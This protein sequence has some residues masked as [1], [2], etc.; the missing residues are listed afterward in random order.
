[1]ES[2]KHVSRTSPTGVGVLVL[3]AALGGAIIGF[4]TFAAS[5]VHYL[6]V[7]FPIGMGFAVGGMISAA[8]RLSRVPNPLMAGSSG[9][10]IGLMS[11]GAMHYSCYIELR[12]GARDFVAAKMAEE[13][14]LDAQ[15]IASFDMRIVDEYFDVTM[16]T[17]TGSTGFW[18]FMKRTASVGMQPRSMYLAP[19]GSS[20][21]R[22]L[23]KS[24]A[25]ALRFFELTIIIGIAFFFAIASA[26][27]PFCA[28]CRLWYS[29]ERHIG[30][31]QED[32][33]ERFLGLMIAGEFAKAG[34]L[35]EDE[36]LPAPSV[37][38]SVQECP[39]TATCERIVAVRVSSCD[40]ENRVETKQV[41]EGMISEDQHANLVAAIR[42][43]SES[44]DENAEDESATAESC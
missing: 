19:S 2:Y 10:L 36:Y 12:W 1:M 4:A 5:L 7:L 34:E 38:V 35:V 9:I 17:D 20:D 32:C 33:A 29:G 15:A 41:L 26:R 40:S 30:S 13:L 11:Y 31:V 16:E 24:A 37:G 25:W 6:I 23:G 22:M 42:H 3:C 28:R 43:D 8:V 44:D 14:G 27:R 18:G 39:S 21:G